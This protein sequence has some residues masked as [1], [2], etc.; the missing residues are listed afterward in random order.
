MER[1]FPIPGR[2]GPPLKKQKTSRQTPRSCL[3]PVTLS[4]T[5][6]PA[7]GIPTAQVERPIFAPPC[8]SNATSTS[9]DLQVFGGPLV[10]MRSHLESTSIA[11]S[12]LATYTLLVTQFVQGCAMASLDWRTDDELDAVMVYILDRWYFEGRPAHDAT[13][14]V[15]AVKWYLPR[16]RRGGAGHLPRSA[17]ALATYARRRPGNQRL[18]LPWV[19]V[20]GMI[21][22][23][24][25]RGHR[26]MALQI[27]IAF[28]GYLRPSESDGI[29]ADNL[30]P[31]AA[32]AGNHYVEWGVL[33]FPSSGDR[34]GKTG[35]WDE[36]IILEGFNPLSSLL[37]ELKTNSRGRPNV[38]PHRPD[39]L[40]RE[41]HTCVELLG[42]EE[43]NPCRYALRHG[44]ASE[45]LLSRRRSV[46]DVKRR[47][48]WVSDSSLRRYGKE[49]RLLKELQKIHPNVLNFGRFVMEHFLEVM[50]GT[51]PVPSLPGR[52]SVSAEVALKIKRLVEVAA[53]SGSLAALR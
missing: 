27:A 13:S 9:D 4:T 12:S 11:P 17:I 31:P 28:W 40:L 49:S 41:W 39:E 25:L 46:Q 2:P 6:A 18:P 53:S 16:F 45:D 30:V 47:G 50:L 15:A 21:G 14:M 48:R 33:L 8:S 38:W 32:L 24:I 42:L 3:A 51:V 1:T 37:M 19:I 35:N 23:M 43:L 36:S 52:G 29:T 26:T 7:V 5:T 34:P 10:W 20:C 44:G 22:V